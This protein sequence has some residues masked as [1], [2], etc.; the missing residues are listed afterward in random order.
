[1]RYYD[2]FPRSHTLTRD[3]G[4]PHSKAMVRTVAKRKC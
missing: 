4:R 1:M 2:E 3:Q